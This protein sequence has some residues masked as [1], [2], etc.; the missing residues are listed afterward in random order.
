MADWMDILEG[1]PETQNPAKQEVAGPPR[2][3]DWETLV[4]GDPSKADLQLVKT[5]WGLRRV[6][7]GTPIPGAKTPEGVPIME[8]QRTEDPAGFGTQVWAGLQDDPQ[9]QIKEYAKA[10]GISP[11]RYGIVGGDVVF[12]GDDGELHYET[13]TSTLLGKVKTAAAGAISHLPEIGLS[14]GLVPAGPGAVALGAAGGAGI[15]KSVAELRSGKARQPTLSPGGVPIV[16]P[17]ENI[18][19]MGLAAGSAF[20]GE[21]IGGKVVR[22]RDVVRSKEAARLVKTAGTGAK[23]MDVAEVKRLQAIAKKHG[24]QLFGPQATGSPELIG[25][26]N[27]LGDLPVTA[28]KIG[29]A[30]LKQYKEIDDAVGKWLNTFGPGSVTAENAGKGA[31]KAAQKGIKSA[32]TIRQNK[33][34]PLYK[35]AFSSGTE[36]DIKPVIKWIDNELETAKGGVMKGLQKAKKLLQAP[37]LP[38]KV[39]T[40]KDVDA[41]IARAQGFDV[42]PE[43]ARVSYDTSLKGLNDAKIAIDD[44]IA[45]AAKAR[46]GNVKRNYVKIKNLL[47]QEMDKTSPEY[48]KARKI[49]SESSGVIDEL[50]GKKGIVGRLSKLEGDDVGKAAQMILSPA[51]STEPVKRAKAVIIKQGGQ[52]A[53]DNLIKTHI[54]SH[55]DKVLASGTKNIGGALRKKIFGNPAQRRVLKEAMTPT[56]FKNWSDLMDVFEATG[57]TAGKESTTATRQVSLV[58]ME[59]EALGAVGRGLVK[60]SKPLY[61]GKRFLADLWARMKTEAYQNKLAD[62]MISGNAT[63]ELKNMLQLQ[64]GSQTLIKRLSVF[65]TSVASGRYLRKKETNVEPATLRMP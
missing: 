36:V 24:I 9:E 32:I 62:A 6:H 58:T 49:F 20:I 37:D 43:Q 27:L 15:R 34:R 13:D 25:R 5:P 63:K 52:K 7:T 53:W 57:K 17:G 2:A 14:T 33:A 48:A 60:L 39:K 26:F 28:D 45:K 64:P 11:D 21:K 61:T 29:A 56:Q 18:K 22:G 50:T 55:Y 42:G 4:F 3:A 51:M 44:E 16:V 65:L 8:A 59:Q 54:F 46:T 38:K 12:I 23:R 19:D 31:V 10:R 1:K 35:K 30:K 47:L 40:G 41:Q